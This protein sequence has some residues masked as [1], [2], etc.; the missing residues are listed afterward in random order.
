M[1]L[2]R[3]VCTRALLS[4]PKSELYAVHILV[5]GQ[6]TILIW[7]K[8]LTFKIGVVME[9]GC[10]HSADSVTQHRVEVVENNF[11]FD[12]LIKFLAN[13]F[14]LRHFFGQF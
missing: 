6:P 12:V 13:S 7:P 3:E 9:N 1:E 14:H 8:S 4:L 5:I 10:Q 11:R 2:L